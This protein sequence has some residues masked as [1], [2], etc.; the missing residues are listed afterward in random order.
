MNRGVKYMSK[1]KLISTTQFIKTTHINLEV[2]AVNSEQFV[3]IV[4]KLG[5]LLQWHFSSKDIYKNLSKSCLG[6]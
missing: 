3:R 5:L 4:P 6:N 2:S 1:I